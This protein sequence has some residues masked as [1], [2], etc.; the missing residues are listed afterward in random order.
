MALKSR[1]G[2]LLDSSLSE[3]L[4][5]TYDRAWQV[6]QFFHRG[7]Y[8]TPGAMPITPEKVA[9]FIAYMD[10]VGHAR[11]TIRTYI[12]ALSREHKLADEYDP[13]AKFLVRKMVDVGGSGAPA[14]RVKRPIKLEILKKIL[15]AANRVLA[16]FDASLMRAV[17]SLAFHACALIG[18]MV[19]S[20]GQSHH[21]VL[22][23]KVAFRAKEVFITF[24]EVRRAGGGQGG[25]ALPT[26]LLRDGRGRRSGP[27]AKQF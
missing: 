7:V 9:M 6:F 13:T 18:E 23:Q 12:S 22:A 15:W 21:A 3:N 19:S 11:T 14:P 1:V 16:E 4:R 20:Y 24:V 27:V 26:T 8:G 17:F 25:Q 2:T 5:K 10:S